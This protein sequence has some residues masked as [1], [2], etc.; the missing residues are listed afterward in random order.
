MAETKDKNGEKGEKSEESKPH[1]CS[2]CA[3]PSDTVICLQCE[4]KVR[5]EVLEHNKDVN[6]AGRT[7]TG[8]R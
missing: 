5:G 4:A 8:R 6:K 1:V 3:R 7:D 2:M